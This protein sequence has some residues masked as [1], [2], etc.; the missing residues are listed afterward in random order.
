MLAVNNKYCPACTST[1]YTS[2]IQN[3]KNLI[4]KKSQL[5]QPTVVTIAA[6]GRELY[7]Q[8]QLRC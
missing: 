4:S 1:E 5:V 8:P 6:K 2:N 7:K 3:S